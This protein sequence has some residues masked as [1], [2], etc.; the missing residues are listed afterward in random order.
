MSLVT[1]RLIAQTMGS[2]VLTRCL[3]HHRYDLHC[4]SPQTHQPFRPK[5]PLR[6]R[7]ASDTNTSKI[8]N[9]EII[10]LKLKHPA[11]TSGGLPEAKMNIRGVAVIPLLDTGVMFS[12]ISTRK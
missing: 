11:P 4:F 7:R 10:T 1:S 6:L 8:L 2:S 9:C 5:Q 3:K 12:V